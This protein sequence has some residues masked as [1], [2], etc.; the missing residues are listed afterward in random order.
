R[1]EAVGR[2][3][4]GETEGGRLA[5]VRKLLLAGE[6]R[7]V[8]G[9]IDDVERGSEPS[10]R[11]GDEPVAANRQ[12]GDQSEQAPVCLRL[13][14]GRDFLAIGGDPHVS[15]VDVSRHIDSYQY[16]VAANQLRTGVGHGHQND[17]P[18][19]LPVTRPR[20]LSG[21]WGER[22]RDRRD[23]RQPPHRPASHWRDLTE[24]LLTEP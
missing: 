22:E 15:R 2:A 13:E 11:R 10:I 20:G 23:R 7:P 16:L 12:A 5:Q 14:A 17:P 1:R 18:W 3:R 6:D 19:R 21:G 8:D 24:N 4:W 9:V